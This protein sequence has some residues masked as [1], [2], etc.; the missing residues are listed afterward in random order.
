MGDELMTQYLALTMLTSK[1][2]HATY[3]STTMLIYGQ[4]TDPNL[5][6]WKAQDC[7]E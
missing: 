5:L 3:A 6:S 2:D 7:L 4:V 1:I